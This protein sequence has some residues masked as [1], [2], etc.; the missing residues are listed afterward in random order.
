MK[1][2]LCIFFFALLAN[3]MSV[4]SAKEKDFVSTVNDLVKAFSLQ[5]SAR[6]ARYIHKPTGVYLLFRQGVFDNIMELNS[7]SFSDESFPQV[8]FKE[9]KGIKALPLK[10][11]PLPKFNCDQSTWS[12][13]GLFANPKQADHLASTICK[14]RNKLVP[15][16]IPTTKITKLYNLELKSRRVVLTGKEYQSLIFYVSYINGKWYLTMVDHVT[17]DCSV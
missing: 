1:K 8:M 13:Q 11:S 6:V 7:I 2:Y 15:D 16:N 4:Q 17:C 12:K 5:D 10:F 14:T 3:T 9:A